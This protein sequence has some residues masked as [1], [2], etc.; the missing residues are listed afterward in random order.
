MYAKY[1]IK[2]KAPKNI[3]YDLKD[4]ADH[5]YKIMPRI[6][7]Q[8]TGRYKSCKVD[9]GLTCEEC[10]SKRETRNAIRGNDQYFLCGNCG[11]SWNMSIMGSSNS[12]L[13]QSGSSG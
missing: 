7:K 5:F 4:L 3:R 9:F 13:K 6:A 1:S 11:E 12:G 2:L 8:I 10:G